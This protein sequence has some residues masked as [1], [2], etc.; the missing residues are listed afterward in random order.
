MSDE[1]DGGP[2]SPLHVLSILI[3]HSQ[4]MPHYHS[5]PAEPFDVCGSFTNIGRCSRKKNHERHNIYQSRNPNY[6]YDSEPFRVSRKDFWLL[7]TVTKLLKGFILKLSHN[8]D[9]LVFQVETLPL[10]KLMCHQC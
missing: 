9:G 6:R 8:A 2:A 7:S 4:R 3:I 1:D 10:K 5:F